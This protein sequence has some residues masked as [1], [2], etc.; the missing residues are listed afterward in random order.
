[1]DDEQLSPPPYQTRSRSRVLLQGSPFQSGRQ[2]IFRAGLRNE[3]SQ[4][5]RSRHV[6]G[7]H[8]SGFAMDDAE[9][10]DLMIQEHDD[11]DLNT[12]LRPQKVHTD[13]S[14]LFLHSLY[15]RIFDRMNKINN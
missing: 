4:E 5:N 13:H 8:D 3:S 1:M 2:S 11:Q 9:D 12:S 7:H 15:C 10:D 6:R 14:Y